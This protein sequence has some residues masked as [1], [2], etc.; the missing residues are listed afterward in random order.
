MDYQKC[1]PAG[2]GVCLAALECEYKVLKQEGPGE[3]PYLSPA[4]WCHGC[5][6]C[7]SAC[8]RRAIMPV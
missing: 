6:K 3:A 2:C 1:R 8:P 5:I 4:R 7:A